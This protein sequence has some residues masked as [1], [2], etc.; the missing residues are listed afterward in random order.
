MPH[1][2]IQPSANPSLPGS[3]WSSAKLMPPRGARKLVARAALDERLINARKARCVLI[4]GPAGSG[5][6][7]TLVQLRKALMRHDFDVAWLSLA[8]EDNTLARFF[9]YLLASLGEVDVAIVREASLLVGHDSHDVAAVEHWI[10]TLVEAITE[11]ERELFLMLDDVH[12]IEDRRILRA[13]QWLLDYAPPHLHIAFGSRRPLALSLGRLQAQDLVATFGLNDLRF[14]SAE[15]EQFLREQLGTIELRDAQTLHELTDGWVAGLQLFAIDLKGKQG[16]SYARVQLRDPQAFASYIEREVLAQLSPDDLDL[17]TRAAVTNRFCASL[18][19]H[20]AGH[21]QAVAQKMGW[22]HRIDTDDLFITQLPGDNR[23]TWYRLHPL[24]REVLLERCGAWPEA[25]RRALHAAA[26]KWFSD[27]GHIDEAVWHAV[28][29][30]KPDEAAD[31]VEACSEDLM[32]R[33]NLSQL[34][35]LLRRLPE[36]LVQ[37]R[38]QLL[39]ATGQL[40][41]YAREYEALD[42]TL[43]RLELKAESAS[44]NER[45]MLDALRA[46]L[47]LQRDDPDS[48][49]AMRERLLDTPPGATERVIMSCNTMLSWMYMCRGEFES[50]QRILNNA[51]THNGAPLQSLACRSIN[52]IALMIEGRTADAEQTLRAVLNES[53]EA[54]AP[55]VGM[56]SMA[57]GVLGHVLYELN[58]LGAVGALLEPRIDLIERTAIPDTVLR[59][60]F[61]LA[62]AH[63]FSGRRLEAR[64]WLD[65]L[66]DHG[67]RLG[68]DRL[69][70]FSLMMRLRTHLALDETDAAHTT[71]RRIEMTAAHHLGRS[72]IVKAELDMLAEHARVL[73]M[74]SEHDYTG[75]ARA[76]DVLLQGAAHWKK[77]RR[78]IG[79]HLQAAVA[80]EA[81]GYPAA[82]REHLHAAV[83]LGHRCGVVRSLLDATPHAPA[84]LEGLLHEECVD[85]VIAFYVRRVLAAS[86]TALMPE[87]GRN[88]TRSEALS[89][90]EI[91]VLSLVAQAM[92]NK[93]IARVINVSPET[94]KWHLKNIYAKLDVSGRDEAVGR[95]RDMEIYLRE[96]EAIEARLKRA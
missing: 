61:A 66:E 53:E 94:V 8:P 25:R 2:V 13:L 86:K 34:G 38:F 49:H 70:V 30:D 23:V 48:I 20:L 87:R 1:T 55:L 68:L 57:A 33:G 79:L 77:Q 12:L 81:R 93:K 17:L 29:A 50:M 74:L 78:L 15:S 88:P 65:R 16:G 26:W 56:A 35:G 46:G 42:C 32:A 43:S 24:L 62:G 64:A 10:I 41:L 11:R 85:P 52:G 71:L 89:E 83:T 28:Q 51:C 95:A 39:L 75:A 96:P 37:T 44:P 4:Q 76:I 31:M 91:E 21:P 82:V 22:L 14:T 40:Q 36:T 19:A 80:N 6:T 72:E 54:G 63:W 3:S 45:Y 9:D 92:P 69:I 59:A 67:A 73:V 84:L 27:H 7:T 5:K 60:H 90:R 18:C 58:D 47:A